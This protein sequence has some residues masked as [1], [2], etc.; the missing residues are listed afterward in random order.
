ME[1]LFP[2]VTGVV[3]VGGKSRRMGTDK[4]LLAVGGRPLYRIALDALRQVV[5]RLLL[6]GG[7]PGGGAAGGRF[8]GEEVPVV[9]DVYPGSS[10]GGL[11][12]GLLRAGT[13]YIFALACDMPSPGPALI[14]QL[15][16]LRGGCD[17]V[18][19]RREGRME[20]LFAA[21]SRVCL[22]PMEHLLA[23][24]NHRIFDFFPEV[25]TRVVEGE[26]LE[27]L[28][29]GGASFVNLNTPGEYRRLR[30]KEGRNG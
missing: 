16:S 12:A 22:G 24:G 13:P 23:A 26:E 5:P 18:V 8:A 30:E 17:V 11:H 19:P 27:R 6:V 7:P 28:D 9:E 25:R 20:P 15:L 10:L 29:A 2:D 21:Y 14:R 4:A 1:D 3:L